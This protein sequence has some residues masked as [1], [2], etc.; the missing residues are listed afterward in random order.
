MQTC[1]STNRLMHTHVYMQ[2]RPYTHHPCTVG[3]S[4]LHP[5]DYTA[6]PLKIM[7][8]NVCLNKMFS[9]GI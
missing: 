4:H 2:K 9:V 5:I 6:L 7:V 3:G 8:R 1:V